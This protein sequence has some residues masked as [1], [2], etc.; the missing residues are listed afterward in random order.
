VAARPSSR[1][2][3]RATTL[4]HAL[5]DVLAA[6]PARARDL[7][8]EVGIPERS[9]ADH[10]AHLERALRPA[11]G[12]FTPPYPDLTEDDVPD[13]DRLRTWT[14]ER[15]QNCPSPTA[16]ELRIESFFPADETTELLFRQAHGAR[17]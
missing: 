8:R 4:R 12:A 1:P 13:V 5:R 10:L 14:Q 17:A 7:S 15:S 6:G 9:V 16:D 2:D 3:L 11:R